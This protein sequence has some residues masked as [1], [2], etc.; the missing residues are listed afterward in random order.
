MIYLHRSERPQGEAIQTAHAQFE[1]VPRKREW[2]SSWVNPA[3]SVWDRGLGG[4]VGVR[5]APG[6][7][8]DELIDEF[9]IFG[10]HG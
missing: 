4:N 5:N 8:G 1:F 7:K 6:T 3:Q 9:G 2:R 10:V